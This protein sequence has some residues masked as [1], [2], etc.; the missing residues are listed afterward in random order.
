MRGITLEVVPSV[1]RRLVFGCQVLGVGLPPSEGLLFHVYLSKK[2][3]QCICHS[4]LGLQVSI[5]DTQPRIQPIL[6]QISIKFWDGQLVVQHEGL[7][8]NGDRCVA[9]SF[10]MCSPIVGQNQHILYHFGLKLIM[11]LSLHIKLLIC[12]CCWIGSCSIKN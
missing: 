5:Q 10:V 1:N 11:L 12:C 6:I 2:N 7:L 4:G 9:R 3:L 8:E